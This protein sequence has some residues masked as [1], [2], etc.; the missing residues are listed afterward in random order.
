VGADAGALGRSAVGSSAGRR[1][2]KND[3]VVNKRPEIF[4]PFVLL[5]QSKVLCT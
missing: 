2:A 4:R 3:R 5:W 1:R